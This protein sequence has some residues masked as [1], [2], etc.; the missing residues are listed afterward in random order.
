[1]TARQPGARTCHFSRGVQRACQRGVGKA[2]GQ[3]PKITG[4]FPVCPFGDHGYDL[5]AEA[6]Q[7]LVRTEKDHAED[8]IGE[9]H[10]WPRSVHYGEFV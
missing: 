5:T 9:R 3:P 7:S 4:C 2:V 6:R 8:I 1:M 10:V